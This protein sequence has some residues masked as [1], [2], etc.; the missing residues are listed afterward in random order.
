MGVDRVEYKKLGENG[1]QIIFTY[2]NHTIDIYELYDD[3]KDAALN[4]LTAPGIPEIL[5]I[6]IREL[7]RLT[8][9]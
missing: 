8:V 5:M 9:H 4:M 3:D 2:D 7:L 6:S 1:V